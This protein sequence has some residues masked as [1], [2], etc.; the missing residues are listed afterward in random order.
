[1]REN[2]N[3]GAT[4]FNSTKEPEMCG[5]GRLLGSGMRSL[6][7]DSRQQD[8]A[9]MCSHILTRRDCD[10]TPDYAPLPTRCAAER[11]A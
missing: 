10:P 5:E 11:Q 4:P 2:S 1:M 6:C 3:P 7:G 9:G 8:A